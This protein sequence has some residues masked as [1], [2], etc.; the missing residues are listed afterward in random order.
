M[1]RLISIF[2]VAVFGFSVSAAADP[3]FKYVDEGFSFCDADMLIWGDP[4]ATMTVITNEGHQYPEYIG[5]A[6]HGY[7]P[8]GAALPK[9]AF[10]Y[11][12]QECGFCGCIMCDDVSKFTVTPKGRVNFWCRMDLE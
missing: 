8:E 6:G 2:L 11:T 4:E 3:A 12:A 9:K 5:V 10:T 7:L 1:K